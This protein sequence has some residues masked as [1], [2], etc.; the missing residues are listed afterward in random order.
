MP[1]SKKPRRKYRPPAYDT[2]KFG[3]LPI[4]IKVAGLE[5]DKQIKPRVHLN[6]LV[7]G[8]LSEEAIDA[9]FYW[10][11]V[12][13][14]VLWGQA[15]FRMFAADSDE[16]AQVFAQAWDR[17]QA[18]KG[19]TEVPPNAVEVIGP[20]LDLT[21]D[22]QQIL[23]RREAAEALRFVRENHQIDVSMLIV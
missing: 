5:A 2:A 3:R 4:T 17:L 8:S 7:Q 19:A 23:T 1:R 21:D 9:R 16:A 10:N 22:L 20:A 11:S 15:M 18:I 14:R 13:G 12:A 6:T